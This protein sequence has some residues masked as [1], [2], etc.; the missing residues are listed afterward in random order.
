MLRSSTFGLALLVVAGNSLAQTDFD[1]LTS[2]LS[3]WDQDDWTLT[4][5][6]YV[7]GQYQS[8]MSLAN[9]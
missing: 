8:R 3:V 9:G 2:N 4:A 7:P 1:V 6:Q 5:T